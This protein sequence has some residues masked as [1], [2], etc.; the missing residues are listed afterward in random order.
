MGVSGRL[1]ADEHLLRSDKAVIDNAI[2][3]APWLHEQPFHHPA[4]QSF[5]TDVLPCS[6]HP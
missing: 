1:V 4:H 2:K 6:L 3:V 5:I